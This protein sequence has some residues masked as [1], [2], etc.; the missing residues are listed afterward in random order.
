MRCGF[1]GFL[2]FFMIFFHNFYVISFCNW[3]SF[4]FVDIYWMF[5]VNALVIKYHVNIYVRDISILLIS[6]IRHEPFIRLWF[7]TNSIENIAKWE[8]K[9]TIQWTTLR[10]WWSSL[11]HIRH[12]GGEG[13]ILVYNPLHKLGHLVIL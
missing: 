4:Q 6:P 5:M 9:S 13:C 12:V 10:W 7:K 8:W 1:D 11:H 2:C 3:I